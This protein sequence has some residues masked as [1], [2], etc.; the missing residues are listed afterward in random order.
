MSQ[1]SVVA[2]PL[3]LL[4]SNVA[5][6]FLAAISG[7]ILSS[8][9]A[10]LQW[11]S[12][13]ITLN[14][15]HLLDSCMGFNILKSRVTCHLQEPPSHGLPFLRT[16]GARYDTY[17]FATTA[18]LSSLILHNRATCSLHRPG[19]STSHTHG[20]SLDLKSF[21]KTVITLLADS[22]QC[23]L[24]NWKLS[25]WQKNEYQ[26]W[27]VWEAWRR[28]IPLSTKELVIIEVCLFSLNM[29]NNWRQQILFFCRRSCWRT[30]GRS[31]LKSGKLFWPS[32]RT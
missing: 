31:S 29:I 26:Q 23:D 1:S 30:E 28:R 8:R 16:M 6:N 24:N 17:K 25:V 27:T 10:S 22:G 18:L 7:V 32:R 15:P 2:I 5:L 11:Q 19:I 20:Q 14:A 4:L 21:L 12:V 3:I 9:L 13:T